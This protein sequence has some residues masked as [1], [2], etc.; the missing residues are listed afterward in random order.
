[1]MVDKLYE[2][3]KKSERN[4]L[5]IP[6]FSGIH[7]SGNNN[8]QDSK[9]IVSRTPEK[10]KVRKLEVPRVL[11]TKELDDFFA[12]AEMVNRTKSQS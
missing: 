12:K 7:D 5:N 9:H 3:A 1:M 6:V 2:L 4:V 10:R 11:Q 8:T